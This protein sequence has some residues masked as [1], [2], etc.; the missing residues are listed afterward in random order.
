[1][2]VGHARTMECRTESAKTMKAGLPVLAASALRHSRR[3]VSR[4]FC[5]GVYEAVVCSRWALIEALEGLAPLVSREPFRGDEVVVDAVSLR[6]MSK[7]SESLRLRPSWVRKA[8]LKVMRVPSELV[9]VSGERVM[10]PARVRAS[11]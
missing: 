1:M 11:K 4:S 9:K 7:V 10:R 2:V 5:A 3:R 8:R 6:R